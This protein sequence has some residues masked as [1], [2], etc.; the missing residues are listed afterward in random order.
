MIVFKTVLKILNKLKGMLI[1]YTIML[2]SI[3]AFNQS[4]T[5]IKTYEET[6]PNIL[7]VNKDN[8]S[9]TKDFINYLDNHTNIKD[10]DKYTKDDIDD[11]IFY[12][13]IDLVLYIPSNF[14]NDITIGNSP[15][16]DY[17]ASNNEDSTYSIMLVEKYLK[18]IDIYKDYYSKEDLS[19]IVKNTLDKEV[20]VE[21]NSTLDSNNLNRMTTYFNFLNYAFL[22]GCVYI[23]SMTLASLKEEHV[24][25]RTIVSSYNYKKYNRIVLLSN[26]LV[27]FILWILYVLLSLFIFKDLLLTKN[28]L[29]FIFN[30][31]IFSICSLTIGFLIGNITSNKNALGGI[32]NVV[33]VGTSFL[34]G[35]FVPM[36]YMPSNVLTLAHILPSYYYVLNNEI[37]KSLETLTLTNIKPLIINS[38]VVLLFSILFIIITNYITKKKQVI[39]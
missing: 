20:K 13:D 22:A 15:K 11:A 25:K 14:G 16:I 29:L 26:A 12:R 38:I 4:S 9:I 37:I 10:I 2:I 28:G 6:K 5:N 1:I 8:T 35:S 39:K 30:S 31:F 21:V 23:I 7:I 19:N 17:K 36:E 27:I 33:A 24:L 32:V 34:C 18:T 3:T